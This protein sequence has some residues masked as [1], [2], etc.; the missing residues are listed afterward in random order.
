MCFTTS[1]FNLSRERRVSIYQSHIFQVTFIPC[2]VTLGSFRKFTCVPVM[3]TVL[4]LR[5]FHASLCREKK[6]VTMVLS[7]KTH[8]RC[9]FWILFIPAEI[10]IHAYV[11]RPFQCMQLFKGVLNLWSTWSIQSYTSCTALIWVPTLL[12]GVSSS[13][14]RDTE[15]SSYYPIN[16]RAP[17]NGTT[18]SIVPQ[19]C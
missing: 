4:H 12:D 14:N 15:I 1:F 7:F 8:S 19:S 6:Q 9:S 5:D 16:D 2:T 10:E 3:L 17:F 13:E 18:P 11:V